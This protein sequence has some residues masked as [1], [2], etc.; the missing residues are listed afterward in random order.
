METQTFIGKSVTYVE[1]FLKK[2]KVDYVITRTAGGKDADILN[3]EFVICVREKTPLEI[4]VTS[5]KT[6]I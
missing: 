5:F 1:D 6:S 2:N 4:I 3:E